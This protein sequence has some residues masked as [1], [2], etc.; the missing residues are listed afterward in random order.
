M[1]WSSSFLSGTTTRRICSGLTLTTHSTVTLLSPASPVAHAQRVLVNP[2]TS[3]RSLQMRKLP[4]R[5]SDGVQ[6]ALLTPRAAVARTLETQVEVLV[7]RRPPLA[8]HSRHAGANV[9]E[10]VTRKYYLSLVISSTNS[11]SVFFIVVRRNVCLVLPVLQCLPLGTTS[12][13]RRA[14]P[15][16][17]RGMGYLVHL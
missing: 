12:V 8:R 14:V 4:T 1:E 6:L 10:M 11:S 17:E 7:R 2:R 9:A 3:N 16:F 5:I 15:R 13:S